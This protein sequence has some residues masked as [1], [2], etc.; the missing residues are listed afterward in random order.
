MCGAGGVSRSLP[1]GDTLPPQ[2]ICRCPGRFIGKGMFYTIRPDPAGPF[3]TSHCHVRLL[4]LVRDIVTDICGIR[5]PASKILGSALAAPC[6]C[7]YHLVITL[8]LNS[9]AEAPPHNLH[10]EK[11]PLLKSIQDHI[12][13]PPLHPHLY[14]RTR[15][16]NPT[17]CDL[18]GVSGGE[19]REVQD[20]FKIA[21]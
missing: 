6:C 21:C 7:Y 12:R 19:E 20:G 2:A 16:A 13:H 15:P 14:P 1:R 10:N 4:R 11:R 17:R 3:S 9:A 5:S 18:N 8:H